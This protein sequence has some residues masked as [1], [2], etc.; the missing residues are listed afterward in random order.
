MIR[1]TFRALPPLLA[2]L[3]TTVWQ[4]MAL[5]S[6][7]TM[8]GRQVFVKKQPVHIRARLLFRRCEDAVQADAQQRGR[9]DQLVLERDHGPTLPGSSIFAR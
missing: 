3:V 6:E 5:P 2:V 4:L 1:V 8:V 7:I 9:E